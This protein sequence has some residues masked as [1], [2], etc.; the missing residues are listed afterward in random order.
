M[1]KVL[2]LFALII[3]AFFY[4]QNS[5]YTV[6]YKVT[7]RSQK[8]KKSEKVEYM[9]LEM[10][11]FKSKFYN[12]DLKKQDS[13]V[14]I[15]DSSITDDT[16]MPNLKFTVYKDLSA[17]QTLVSSIFNQ[18]EVVY[19]EQPLKYTL[20]N[21]SKSFKVEKY[22]VKMAKVDFGGRNWIIEYIPDI[23]LFDGPYVFSGL[24]G[25]V[26]QAI[27]KD[28]EYD[29]KLISIT[30]NSEMK[31]ISIP[32]GN[33][34]KEVYAKK[35]QE[36]LKDPAHHDILYKNIWGDQFHY[37]YIGQSPEEIKKQE[38]NF[39]KIIDNFNNPIDKDVFLLN[40]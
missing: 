16:E 11:D 17:K 15:N 32:K 31:A 29:F 24:P 36:F 2:S 39:Q 10:K 26:F 27:S 28:L 38:Q 6:L 34:K 4:S 40:F 13:L 33:V 18:T 8:E 37:K 7:Y 35:L 20:D 9:A 12:L 3:F 21:N 25:L 1:K 5:G 30:K 14:A 23:P 22:N 19:K